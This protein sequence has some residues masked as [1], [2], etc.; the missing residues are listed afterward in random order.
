MANT[1]ISTFDD[2]P[3]RDVVDGEGDSYLGGDGQRPKNNGQVCSLPVIHHIGS[4][5][6]IR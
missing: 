3:L 4:L 1:Q 6:I 5:T 2:N